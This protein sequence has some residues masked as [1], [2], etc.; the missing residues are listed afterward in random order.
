M[1][2]ARLLLLMS[3][4]SAVASAQTVSGIVVDEKGAP[5]SGVRVKLNKVTDADGRFEDVTPPIVLRKPEYVSKFV[6]PDAEG[7]LRVVLDTAP[8]KW[9]PVCQK[10]CASPGRFCFAFTR[11][12]S[13]SSGHGID[14]LYD[15]YSRGRGTLV[16]GSGSSWS[17]G[18]PSDLDISKSVE[19]SEVSFNDGHILDERGKTRA[20]KYRRFIDSVG[21]SA[22]YRDTDEVTSRIFDKVLDSVCLVPR[23][24]L[25]Q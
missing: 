4:I 1:I 24:P 2:S 7:E 12:V 8:Q 11:G 23:V 25:K 10:K 5:L 16:H 22:G 3:L 13:K 14:A 17:F 18:T 21:E 20:G 19:Y 6:G 9:I 15:E